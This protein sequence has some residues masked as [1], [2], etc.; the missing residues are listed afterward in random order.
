[1]CLSISHLRDLL[2]KYSISFDSEYEMKNV[3]NIFD[4]GFLDFLVHL[5]KDQIPF[6]SEKIY[7]NIYNFFPSCFHEKLGFIDRHLVIPIYFQ[8]VSLK[9]HMCR[10][11]KYLCFFYKNSQIKR[12]KCGLWFQVRLV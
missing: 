5:G 1:M 9:K 11:K 10:Y 7:D 6:F 12:N 2:K 8:T 4:K 3:S